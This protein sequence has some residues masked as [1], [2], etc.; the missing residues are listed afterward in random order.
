LLENIFHF[1]WL[2]AC[3]IIVMKEAL[4]RVVKNARKVLREMFIRRFGTGCP[5]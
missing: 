4:V 5:S 3:E 2:K 1:H